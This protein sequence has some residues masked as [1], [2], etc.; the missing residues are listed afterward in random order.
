MFSLPL[1][2]SGSDDEQEAL[3]TINEELGEIE[4]E[5]VRIGIS[6]IL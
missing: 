5:E 3:K 1:V 4:V 6:G 2:S